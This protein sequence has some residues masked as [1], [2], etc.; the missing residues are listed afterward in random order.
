MKCAKYV[1]GFGVFAVLM[2]HNRME[3]GKEERGRETELSVLHAEI[4][5][6]TYCSLIRATF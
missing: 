4:F 1:I 5:Q 2:E 6:I 3:G